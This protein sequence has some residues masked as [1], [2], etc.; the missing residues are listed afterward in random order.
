MVLLS[1]MFWAS[2]YNCIVPA[3]VMKTLSIIMFNEA[4]WKHFHSFCPLWHFGFYVK[5]V[6]YEKIPVIQV[7]IS[8]ILG[9]TSSALLAKEISCFKC[10]EKRFIKSLWIQI[11][12]S[13]FTNVVSD[14]RVLWRELFLILITIL[15][16]KGR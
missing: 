6:I 1:K 10:P 13:K 14:N 3:W 7:I 9:T 5:H 15:R 8:W 12:K 16:S 2:E 4:S 11:S